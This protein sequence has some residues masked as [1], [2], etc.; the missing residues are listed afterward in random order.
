MHLLKIDVE[1][2]NCHA[3][4]S[5]SKLL[6]ANRVQYIVMEIMPMDQCGCD[7]NTTFS[8]LF[9][10]VGMRFAACV[11][12]SPMC[13]HAHAVGFVCVRAMQLELCPV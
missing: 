8:Y 3:L 5:A 4:K 12:G 7:G 10:C 2:C 1:G 6:E 13:M 11:A 9:E